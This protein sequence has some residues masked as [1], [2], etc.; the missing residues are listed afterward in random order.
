[1]LQKNMQSFMLLL[2]R[3]RHERIK[4]SIYEWKDIASESDVK[5]REQPK[6][7]FAEFYPI[8][9]FQSVQAILQLF[10]IG[11]KLLPILR[12]S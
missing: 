11:N 6:I 7:Q 2:W 8:S 4:N 9:P 10:S 1:M 5:C 12:N 3:K